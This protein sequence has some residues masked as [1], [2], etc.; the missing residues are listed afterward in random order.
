M[1]HDLREYPCHWWPLTCTDRLTCTTS[2]EV[3]MAYVAYQ[4]HQSYGWTA[5]RLGDCE[6]APDAREWGKVLFLSD[7]SAYPR[8]PKRKEP[9]PCHAM[10][11]IKQ[12]AD[13]CCRQLVTREVPMGPWKQ[14][15]WWK[16]EGKVRGCSV[17]KVVQALGCQCVTEAGFQ[18]R[19]RKVYCDT[20][21]T[22]TVCTQ[23][24]KSGTVP[25]TMGPV[26]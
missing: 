22:S 11:K 24:S 15:H 16:V 25:I 6:D 19:T 26:A 3:K 9:G 21:A 14:R 1:G 17:D 12:R 10:E 4:M 8:R 2:V 20:V 13:I 7:I 23:V 18:V 5:V